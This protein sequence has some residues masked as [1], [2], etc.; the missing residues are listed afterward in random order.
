MSLQNYNFVHHPL[1][2]KPRIF[3]T[4]PSNKPIDLLIKIIERPAPNIIKYN[5]NKLKLIVRPLIIYSKKV[6]LNIFQLRQKK[7]AFLHNGK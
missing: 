6:Q 5:R 7:V 3:T 4:I 1:P 2:Q